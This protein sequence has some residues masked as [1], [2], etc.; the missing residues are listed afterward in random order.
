[1]NNKQR[2]VNVPNSVT[3]ARLAGSIFESVQYARTGELRHFV[4]AA[5]WFVADVFDGPA[6]R[7]LNQETEFGAKFDPIVDKASVAGLAAAAIARHNV[8][9][10][11]F[12]AVAAV[13]ASNAAATLVEQSR[14]DEAGS[15]P[16]VGKKS[17]FKMNV[18]LSLN[19]IGNHLRGAPSASESQ[20]VAGQIIRF[21]GGALAIGTAFSQGADAS[22]FYWKRAIRNKDTEEQP[23]LKLVQIA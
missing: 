1:M 17:Q 15:V 12:A 6:A 11:V 13:N 3:G 4:K 20:R 21:V 19:V 5:A 22:A 2:L 14:H 7:A 16:D 18:G 23:T 9:L 8:D 10:P